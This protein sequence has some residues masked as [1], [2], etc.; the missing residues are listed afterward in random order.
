MGVVELTILIVLLLVVAALHSWVETPVT[1]ESIYPHAAN[2]HSAVG[3]P[4]SRTMSKHD[5]QYTPF[6]IKFEGA[7][8]SHAVIVPQE[9]DV[10]RVIH[11]FDL[12]KPRPAIFLTG[13]ASNMSAADFENTRAVMEFGIAEFA[14]KHNITIIDGG[15]EAGIMQMLGDVRKRRNFTFP[16]IG[17]APLSL[18]SFPGPQSVG[19][20]AELEDGHSHFVLVQGDKWG[21]ES[22]TIIGLTQ[23]IA[24]K[25]KPKLGILINGGKI[26]ER[27]A[28]LATDSANQ[29]DTIRILVLDGS[30]RAAS[31]ISTAFK[32]GHTDSWMIR[33]II[34]RDLLI[35][36]LSKGPKDMHDKLNAHFQFEQ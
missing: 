18:V 1:T 9:G 21:D 8:Y 33:E 12:H 16:L 4:E 30:G 10:D 17:V 27:E 23:A 14:E 28:Y 6:T 32:T 26:A 11:L 24:A 25:A 35:A 5:K 29:S 19:T 3:A 36:E 31:D 2:T 13:G 34:E 7:R 20:E 15:T 22:H